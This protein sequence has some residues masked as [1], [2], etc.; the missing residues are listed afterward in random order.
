MARTHVS[1]RH[2]LRA[3][4]VA[5]ALPALDAMADAAPHSDATMTPRRMVIICTSLGLHGPSLYPEQAGVLNGSTPYLQLLQEH[6]PNMT[7]FGG[8][9]HPDQAGANGHS[10]EMTWLTAATHPGLN[11][12]RNSISIDQFA[13]EHLGQPTRFATMELSTHGASSQSYTSA[14]VMRS[15]ESRPSVV[16]ERLFLQGNPQE[17]ERQR[18]LLR[19]GQSVLDGVLDQTKRLKT[20]ISKAD[21]ERLDAYWDA[22]RKTESEL[23]VA[24]E[25]LEKPKPTVDRDRPADIEAENDL[26]GRTRLWT[27]LIPLILQT[28][29][30]RILTL[31]IQGRNDV[32]PIPGVTLDHHNLSH[33]GQ[34]EAKIAQLQRIEQEIMR[35]FGSL[36][37]GLKRSSE[38]ERTLL[39]QT[40][41]LFGSNL[42]NA[43][44]HDW[45]NLPIAL[46]GGA[47]S[48]GRHV[49]YDP[50]NNVPLCNLFV[51][52]LREHLQ[53]DID[54]FGTST[55]SLNW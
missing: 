32:P 28:D 13:R 40:A 37:D 9:S 55:S 38:G 31:M 45:H 24:G 26:I 25:W 5:V 27:D 15:A 2:F 51:S 21:R 46:A 1:R 52:V 49:A 53:L 10:S 3:S 12:F 43:N 11:G 7:L 42:G 36:L 39:D 50:K 29:S 54:R 23:Q 44:S 18:M 35:C 19:D 8:L 14:G 48:H 6:L 4:G 33:H 16:F 41:V 17:L 22:L 30:T 20:R 34:D 47:F